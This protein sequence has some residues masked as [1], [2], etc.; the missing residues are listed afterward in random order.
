MRKCTSRAPASRIICTI[1]TDVVPR[2]ME[3]SMRMMRLIL[4]HR[5]VGIMLQ[6]HAEFAHRLLRLDEGAP[7]I[8]VAD[9]AELEGNAG[10]LRIADRRGHAR[11]RHRH[12]DVGIDRGFAGELGAHFLAHFVDRTSL[13]DGIGPREIDEFENARPHRLRRKRPQRLDAVRKFRALLEITT[14][15]PFSTSRTKRAPMMSSA[16]VSEARM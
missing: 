3:S 4:H 9:D 2:T 1:F 13:N 6:P 14:I 5:A 10:G 11:I 8:M 16:Q 12:D 7:D 15:S